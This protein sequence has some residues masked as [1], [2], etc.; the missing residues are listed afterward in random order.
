MNK[1]IDILIKNANIIYPDKGT[2]ERGTI[3]IYNGKFIKYDHKESYVIRDEINA[4]GYYV[5]PGWIDSHTHIFKDVTEP[6]FAADLGLIPMGITSTIDGGSAGIG[7][8]P[9]FKHHIV[10]DNYLNVFYSINVSP[11]GQITERYPENV[12]PQHYD[13][14]KLKTIMEKDPEHI[15]GLKLRYGAEVV[16]PFGN[17][18]LDK[19]LE[20]A[21][22]LH[23]QIT[24]HVTN[25]P[26]DME[27]IIS[28]M[29]PGDIVCHIYQGKGSTII[30]ENG[31]VKEAIFKAR[32]RGVYFD[33]A[34]ARI[35][36]CYKVIEPAIAQNF[37]PDIISTDLT[38]NGIFS[39]MS[40]GLP[41]V[42]SKWL[43]LGL[44]LEE[45]I[46]DCTCHPAEIYCLP[47]GIGTLANNA[48][49]NVTIF[50]VENRHFHLKN[51]MGEEFDGEKMI[52][53]QVTI[54][55]GKVRYKNLYFP[56]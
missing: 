49:A 19:T 32:K 12:D 54:I 52:I 1:I 10:D 56:F 45:V 8:W 44:T 36:H 26:C 5:S 16:E 23:C 9:I 41:V 22:S 43:N 51:R 48:A 35:N 53:P 33:S 18:V 3:A 46:A 37:K 42:L 17:S 20:L 50:S 40:W 55:N 2:V 29:R 6:G 21:D 15:R 39:N 25:P 34:D 28:K 7:T 4:D 47:N 13:T 24:L 30:D 31:K 27:E 14:D 11:S 38:Q